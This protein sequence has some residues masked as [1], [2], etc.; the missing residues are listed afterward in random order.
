[1]MENDTV[2]DCTCAAAGHLVE[3]WSANASAI[4]VPSDS[5]IIAAYSAITGFDPATGY[6]D[7]GANELDVLNYWRQTGIAGRKIGAYA[8]LEPGNH[9]HVMDVVYLFGGCYIG[10]ALPVSAQAQDIWSVPPGGAIGQGA[11]GSWGGHAVPIV[12][13]DSGG[14]TCVTWGVSSE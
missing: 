2:G 5:Q 9:D 10:L 6:D 4:I 14:L 11:A 3:C 7:N 8:A 1:M 13:Y 12:A